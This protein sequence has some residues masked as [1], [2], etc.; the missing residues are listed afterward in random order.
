MGR[1]F[2]TD[3]I[4]G[5]A[6][7]DLS[8]ELVDRLARAAVE[9]L[10]GTV[11]GRF[12]LGRDPRISGDLLEAAMAAG[13]CSAGSDVLRLGVLPTPGVAH[14]ARAL[15]ANAGIVISASH[16][17]VEDNGV[18]FFSET[19]FK[20]PDAVEAAIEAAMG[21]VL[22]RSRPTGRDVGRIH[23][24]PEAG[25]RY[26]SYV[27]GLA[28]GRLGGWRVVLDCANGATSRIAP[29]LWERLGATVIPLYAAPDGTNINV[30][31]GS[32]HPEVIQAAVVTHH[33]DLGFAH[34][35]D[36]DRVIA[37]D[38]HG[39]LV[40][41]DTIMGI[42][43]LDRHARGQLP[44]NLVVATVM[45]NL[46]LEQALRGAGIRLE[47]VRVGDR[48][49]LERMLETG[50]QVGGEQSGHVLFLDRATTGDGLVTAVELVNVILDSG[51]PLD[52]LRAPFIRYP[53]IL[54]N[55][56]V[57]DPGRWA[58]DPEIAKA[59]RRAERRLGGRGRVL[60]RASGTE[61]LVR[62][63]AEHEEAELAESIARELSDLIGRRLGGGA[64]APLGK[65]QRPGSRLRPQ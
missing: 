62:V 38:R 16:N 42:T 58:S 37:A 49:V 44:G 40:D 45:S 20:L 21:G 52:D 13:I 57:A 41:G 34:D 61:P 35:G 53:Q 19:G 65:K 4:R 22:E 24:M 17:P 31:C 9:V 39:Q 1:L 26:L 11:R 14:L 30:G 27:Q 3:G 54:M 12:A 28:R 55:V 36:G 48:Y 59:A 32:T 64:S 18:K 5:I 6:N 10:A 60:I 50:A 29:A 33:A 2:G 7:A 56:R 46:G 47:R 8:T 43:A 23:E 51:R 15:A 63:M 25:E